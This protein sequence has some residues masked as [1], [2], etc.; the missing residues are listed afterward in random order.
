MEGMPAA[1]ACRVS[2]ESTSSTTLPG[3][4]RV[5]SSPSSARISAE[6]RRPAKMISRGAP[7]MNSQAPSICGIATGATESRLAKAA[8]VRSAD[9]PKSARFVIRARRNRFITAT[10]LPAGSA[11][12]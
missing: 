11:P 12:S 3:T 7:A 9:L 1:S 10:E 8:S 5:C 2:T 6:S 4:K